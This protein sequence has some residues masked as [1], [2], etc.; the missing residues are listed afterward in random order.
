MRDEMDARLWVD[1]H[2]AF[3]RDLDRG[4]EKLRLGLFR[5]WQ[6]DGSVAQAVA[7]VAAFALTAL[8]FSATTA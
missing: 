1:H 6:W 4:L 2:E 7:F 8:S 3:S 5:L